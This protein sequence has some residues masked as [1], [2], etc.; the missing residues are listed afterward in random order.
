MN[1][2]QENLIDKI[3]LIMND[4]IENNPVT[5]NTKT[6]PYQAY[7]RIGFKGLRWSVEKRIKEYRLE[8][9]F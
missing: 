3:H 6:T 4:E 2:E 9:F 8:Q 1:K 5:Y 7:E